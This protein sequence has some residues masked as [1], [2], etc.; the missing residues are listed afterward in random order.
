M[1]DN[2]GLTVRWSARHARLAFSMKFSMKGGVE[3]NGGGGTESDHHI[4]KVQ[5]GK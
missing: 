3:P 5:I 4:A 2:A 1:G